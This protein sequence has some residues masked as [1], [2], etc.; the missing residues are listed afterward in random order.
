MNYSI[1]EV[2][3]LLGMTP[4]ALHYYEK[5]G[6]IDTPKEES[7][8]RYYED[9]DVYRLISARKYRNMGVRLRDIARQFGGDGMS[10]RQVLDRMRERQKEA[11]LLARKYAGLER[12]IAQLIAAGEEG[13]GEL[14]CVDIRPVPEMLVFHGTDG[15]MVPRDKAEQALARSW[16]EAM[17]AVCLG[18]VH[19]KDA[20]KGALSFLISSERAEEF[21]FKPDGGAV[22][23][24]PSGMAIHAVVACGEE[25]Y[26]NPDVIFGKVSEFAR[27]HRFPENGTMWGRVLFVDCS[28][29]DR[30]HFYETY[31]MI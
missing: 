8:W 21:G 20:E 12:D 31:K 16:L 6:I 26:E 10:G 14:N 2:Y 24:I 5:E 19:E 9:V 11:A 27:E 3:R 7:G 17:P 15:N 29:G 1:G 30:R 22:K 23:S 28:G 13:L 4:S 18:I 25:Q